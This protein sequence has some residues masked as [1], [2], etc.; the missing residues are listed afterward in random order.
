MTYIWHV[1]IYSKKHDRPIK[2]D[3]S[4]DHDPTSNEVR[5]QIAKQ[6]PC[7][8]WNGRARITRVGTLVNEGFC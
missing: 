3:L 1:I 4:F 8:R 5:D 7:H 2:V 6:Y